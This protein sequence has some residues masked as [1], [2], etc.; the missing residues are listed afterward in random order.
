MIVL[1]CFVW[2]VLQLSVLPQ[3]A[4]ATTAGPFSTWDSGLRLKKH[5]ARTPNSHE[6][7]GA[8]TQKR[9]CSSVFAR[10]KVDA[11]GMVIMLLARVEAWNTMPFV[12][13]SPVPAITALKNSDQRSGRPELPVNIKVSARSC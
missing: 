6:C 10:I 1:F 9:T 11:L 4:S 3:W 2:F 13:L 7:A 5:V 12:H 8:P